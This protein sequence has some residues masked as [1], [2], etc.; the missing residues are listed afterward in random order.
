MAIADEIKE[1]FR[2]GGV[3]TRLIYVNVGV[4]L[5]FLILDAFFSLAQHAEWAYIIKSWFSV[6]ADPGAL[7]L[8]PW[9]IFTY[10]FLHFNFMHILFNMLYLFWFGRIF[11]QFFWMAAPV[12]HY[13]NGCVMIAS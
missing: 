9:S 8:K 7:L 5:V 3:V 10:M 6:P 4:F 11:L 13:P 12:K 2:Q 1:S